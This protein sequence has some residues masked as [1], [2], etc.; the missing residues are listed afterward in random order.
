[1][2]QEQ[3]F[4]P[5][6]INVG[7][8]NRQDT[9]TK[10]LAYVIYYK[11]NVLHK[12]ASWNS[13]RDKKI[14]PIEYQNV[15]TEGFVLNK[16][17][18]GVRAS[19]GWNSR[20]EY[21]RVYDPRDF[22]F[23]ISVANLLFILRECNCSKGKGLEGKFVYAWGGKDL[24]L[25]PEIS[26]DYQKSK[27]YT[28]LQDQK[29]KAKSL[30]PGASYQTKKQKILTYVNKFDFY[31]VVYPDWHGK[32]KNP[33]GVIKKYVF[34]NSE[35]KNFVYL[36][37]M[38]SLANLNSDSVHPDY[39]KFVDR[40][41][42]SQYG[43]KIVN[44]SLRKTNIKQKD[45][46]DSSRFAVDPENE[47]CFLECGIN[48]GHDH[49][50]TSISNRIKL[51][52]GILK[53]ERLDKSSYLTPELLAEGKKEIESNNRYYGYSYD[54]QSKWRKDALDKLCSYH[55][56][57]PDSLL[58]AKLESGSEYSVHRDELRQIK[59]GE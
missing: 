47:N 44:L 50:F 12:E 25:L 38:S 43:S 59:G 57:Q 2:S 8:Q 34:W 10:K 58:I 9:Y 24:I 39:A 41:I 23:E 7:F 40:F 45:W 31:S 17:V 37:D 52:D 3:L 4:I 21:I 27:T 28:G 33:D 18:G 36:D 14:S 46:Y 32:I 26:T 49:I 19:Y 11:K 55:L 53:V 48:H 6:R 56:P 15:P 16:G 22:E 20:N 42:K 54:S 35:E 29:V 51:V 30:I 13:W 5:D 1:M